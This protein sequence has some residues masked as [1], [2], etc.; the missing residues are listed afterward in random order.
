MAR[1]EREGELRRCGSTTREAADE[2]L[3]AAC[4]ELQAVLDAQRT[5]SASLRSNAETAAAQGAEATRGMRA[6]GQKLAEAVASLA[7]GSLDATGSVHDAA[8]AARRDF[9]LQQREKVSTDAEAAVCIRNSIDDALTARRRLR[10][11][12]NHACG[13][14]Q[15]RTG[16]AG[17]G[18]HNSRRKIR[19]RKHRGRSNRN[20]YL[21]EARAACSKSRCAA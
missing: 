18:C 13:V 7:E 16:C 19:S 15:G 21:R 14:G 2:A 20:S 12:R 1:N 10:M 6:Q 5:S 9:A 3:R 4:A 17:R 8:I 11:M